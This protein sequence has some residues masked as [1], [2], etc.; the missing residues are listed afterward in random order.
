MSDKERMIRKINEYCKV[1][2]T[3]EIQG[4]S[5]IFLSD[6]TDN[7]NIMLL[8]ELGQDGIIKFDDFQIKVTQLPSCRNYFTKKP[9]RI[10]TFIMKNVWQVIIGVII[11]IIILYLAIK[12]GLS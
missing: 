10:L 7:R 1:K 8:K 4:S 5:Y 11:G 2:E 3:D 6:L 9:H 12:F